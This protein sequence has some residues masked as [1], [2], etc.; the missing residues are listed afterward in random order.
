M[1][2]FVVVVAKP[3][4][5]VPGE[6]LRLLHQTDSRELA[7]AAERH[8]AW[9]D[10]A[11]RVAFA[12]WAAPTQV[13]QVG[14]HWHTNE[15]GLTAFS[16]RPWPRGGMW[17]PD[18]SWAEQLATFWETRSPL[19]GQPLG[20]IY[21]AV[22]LA[23]DGTGTI[24]TDPLSIAMLYRAETDDVVAYATSARLAARLAAGPDVEPDRDPLSV[25]WLPFLGWIVGD[26]T[27]YASTRVLP[28][29]S[30]V[31]IGPAYGSRVR[32]AHPTPWAGDLPSDPDE[33]IDLVHADLSASVRSVA[34][35]PAPR[36][37]ADIT[38]GKDSR[39]VVALML[40]EGVADRFTFFTS[41]YD[42]S[43][44]VIVG[45]RIA[46]RFGLAHEQPQPGTM[47]D[48]NFRRHLATHVFQTSGMFSAWEMKGRLWASP[49][50]KV[51]GSVG[52]TL[53]TNYSAYP[54]LSTVADLR[55]QF[56]GRNALL[57]ASVLR[58][59]VRAE[60]RAALDA[61]L[62]ERTDTGGSAPQDLLDT[63]YVRW[64]L[65]R[66]FG[67]YEELGE[68]GRAFPLYSLVG[69]QAA[70]ALGAERRR[71]DTLHFE[72]TRR[73]APELAKMPLADVGWPDALL[74]DLPDADDYRAPAVRHEG[75]GPAPTQ[76]RPQ[77]LL[78]N[79]E[80]ARDLLLDERSSPVYDILDREAVERVLRTPEQ[81]TPVQCRQLFGALAAAVW[82]GRHESRARLGTVPTP[83][84]FPSPAVAA[85]PSAPPAAPPTAPR[86]ETRR[87]RIVDIHRRV[88]ARLAR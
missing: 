82:L 56:H 57:R 14:S 71:L 62:V 43:P 9:S 77:R 32:F 75:D 15:R 29:G 67:T 20:G 65:R 88:R 6:L 35:L 17:R 33:L 86:S 72:V 76:W 41:G 4:R 83:D 2:S 84:D 87:R 64:R 58:D 11:G 45:S 28:A 24:V 8:I 22:S 80:A 59:D 19:D 51:S 1:H 12:G 79:L 40:E 21:T 37:H 70:F 27:G 68:A 13:G 85:P 31:E 3:A 42:H 52:E 73:A 18:T 81:A 78:D 54:A 7:F 23:P 36:R 63:F 10:E 69:L 49:A 47:T 53:R 50:L 16:G 5:R 60:L 55:T 48:E 39:L 30:Y 44:D 74:V 61:E 46:E 34:Q 38:G 66:W 26:R 25:A